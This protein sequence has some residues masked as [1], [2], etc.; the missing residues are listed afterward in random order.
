[1][2]R[3]RRGDEGEKIKAV[4]RNDTLMIFGIISIHLCVV[5][6]YLEFHLKKMMD[7]LR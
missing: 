6:E 4:F 2:P 3:L 1:M 5:L 7:A